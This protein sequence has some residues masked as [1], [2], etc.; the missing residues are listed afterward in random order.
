MNGPLVHDDEDWL[1]DNREGR[2][3]SVAF[4]LKNNYMHNLDMLHLG[5]H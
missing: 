3:C 2:L 5:R 1:D 4:K